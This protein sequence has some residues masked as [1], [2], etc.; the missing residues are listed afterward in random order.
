MKGGKR[1][2]IVPLSPQAIEVLQELWQYRKN[3]TWMFPGD[4]ANECMSNNTILKAL[5]RIGFK[6]KMTGHGFR[7]L[8]STLLHE[9]GF[10]DEHIELQLAHAPENDVAAAYNHAKYLGP[11][12]KMMRWWAE[13]LDQ[14]LEQGKARS[15]GGSD[16]N[17][18][19]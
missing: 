10:E 14:M 11:R 4:R 19:S 8:A 17:D 13:Y 12:R 1:Q 15:T 16:F 6:G 5:E 2:H 7:G 3:D 9:H 18:R